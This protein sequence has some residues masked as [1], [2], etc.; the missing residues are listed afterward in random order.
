MSGL[1]LAG[2]FGEGEWGKLVFQLKPFEDLRIFGERFHQAWTRLGKAER[3]PEEPRVVVRC[4]VAVN[5]PH[6]ATLRLVALRRELYAQLRGRR[7]PRPERRGDVHHRCPERRDRQ[8][9][10]CQRDVG[11]ARQSG[12]IVERIDERGPAVEIPPDV[13]LRGPAVLAL[14]HEDMEPPDAHEREA[15]LVLARLDQ[16]WIELPT[17]D[18]RRR[19]G[20]VTPERAPHIRLRG[21]PS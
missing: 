10:R 3:G 20:S 19:H 8:H 17:D 9:A 11:V 14:E 4:S 13:R 5:Q 18:I 16:S 6:R 2:A 7:L 15:E 1:S 12:Q 21:W